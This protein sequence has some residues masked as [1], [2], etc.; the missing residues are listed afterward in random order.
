MTLS[1]YSNP[2]DIPKFHKGDKVYFIGDPSV[3]SLE[4]D[5]RYEVVECVPSS[6][7]HYALT[8][9]VNDVMIISDNPNNYVSEDEYK[10]IKKKE[11]TNNFQGGDIVYYNGP[12]NYGFEKDHAYTLFSSPN[13]DSF[14]LKAG[15]TH[16]EISREVANIYFI[17]QEYYKKMKGYTHEPDSSKIN[18]QSISNYK[19]YSRFNVG[20][21]VYYIGIEIRELKNDFPYLV[22][23]YNSDRKLVRINNVIIDESEVISKKEYDRINFED[24]SETVEII[25]KPR[26][27]MDIKR[28]I[29]NDTKTGKLKWFRPFSSVDRWFRTLIKLEKPT[30]S[31]L[32]IDIYSSKTDGG[33]WSMSIYYHRNKE[34]TKIEDNGILVKQYPEGTIIKTLANNIQRSLKEE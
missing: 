13:G 7:K 5:V 9:K 12:N 8:I 22:E 25:G 17:S 15:K 31:Y 24:D 4:R 30:G 29:W 3:R 2:L 6:K 14:S 20:D 16:K 23:L 32:K 33:K 26:D 21:T 19:K 28:Q 34:K 18:I 10:R 11:N 1:P 27:E